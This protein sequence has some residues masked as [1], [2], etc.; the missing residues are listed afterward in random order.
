MD[1][2]LE[3]ITLLARELSHSL[4]LEEQLQRTV[5]CAA[6]IIGAP[7]GSVRLFDATRARLIAKCRFGEPLHPGTAAAEFRVGEG[8][9]GWIAEHNQPLRTGDAPTDARYVSKAEVREPFLSFIG[10]PLTSGNV[11]FG[12]ISA[13]SPAP[14]A[15]TA[16][17]ESLLS[18]LAG[19]VAPYLEMARLSR[20]AAIDPLTG[21]FNRRGLDLVL[22]EH[23][24]RLVS[25]A[26]CDLDRF[27]R[28][29]DE[30]GHAAGDELLRRVAALLASVVRAADGVV[31]W[32]GEEFLVI[33]AGV[34]RPLAQYIVERARKSVEDDVIIVGGQALRITISVGVAE[35]RPGEP[36]DALIARADEALY[37]AK[38][39]G[40]NR[41]ELAA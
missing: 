12:V 41:V 27:K 5:D 24:G 21:V 32:G 3:R 9:L 1:A 20:L 10:V 15:F 31:R 14:N 8:L 38:N 29:N 4:P 34:D 7:R 40:R 25:V 26:M 11:C 18:L 17:H 30:H 16:E 2:S 36:R 33:L 28:V 39:S 35:R 37:V 6:A 19:L 13:S 22:P 23:D